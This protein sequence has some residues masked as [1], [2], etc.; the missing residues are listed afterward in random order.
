M[1][2]HKRNHSP[3]LILL[4]CLLSAAALCGCG[5][6]GKLDEGDCKCTISFVDIPKELSMLEE[7]VQKNFSINLTLKNINTEKAYEISLNQDNNFSQEV[8][9]NP[10]VYAVNYLYA[11][12]YAYTNL[13][14]VANVDNVELSPDSPSEILIYVE[15]KD[16]LT[17]HWMSVQ[18][19]PEMLLAD[20]FDGRIQINRQILDLRAD[21]ISPLVAQLNLEH[22]QQVPAYGKITLSD[23]DMGVTLTLQNQSETPADWHTCKLLGIEVNRN[24][25]VFPQG[26]TLGM[27]HRTV[28]HK[29][30]GLYGE[31]DSF[32]GTIMYG[33]GFDNTYAVYQ[34]TETGDKITLNLG[35]DGSEIVSI[36]Y[37]LEQFE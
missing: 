21:D 20:K 25:V 5:K 14:V 24:N 7:N 30:E 9:L 23:W 15:D 12:Q 32:T 28:C 22:D 4:L 31:P 2:K 33:V 17:E 35:A 1:Q 18:P 27:S 19:M 10:G 3:Y 6:K 26:V 8:S 13:S 29:T 34:D 37:E 16:K 11:S 36:Q